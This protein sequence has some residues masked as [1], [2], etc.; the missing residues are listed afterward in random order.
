MEYT[1]YSNV[2]T[3]HLPPLLKNELEE[4]YLLYSTMYPYLV[5]KNI[6]Y[7]VH[8]CHLP[9]LLKYEHH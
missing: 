5:Q 3:C 4:L 6:M 7:I 8:T 1:L 2:H 9:P